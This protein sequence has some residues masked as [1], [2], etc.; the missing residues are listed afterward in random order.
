M[1]QSMETEGRRD[2]SRLE[3]FYHECICDLVR[4]ADTTPG[5]IAAIHHFKVKL[6]RLLT[7]RLERAG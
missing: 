7:Q 6:V 5:A 4:A 3:D 2:L 1:V